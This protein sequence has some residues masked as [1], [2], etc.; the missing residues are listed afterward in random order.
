MMVTET[1][2]MVVMNQGPHKGPS[3]GEKEVDVVLGKIAVPTVHV[4]VI[5]GTVLKTLLSLLPSHSVF[6]E[7]FRESTNM[8]IYSIYLFKS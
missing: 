7:A 3:R 8:N 6:C 2:R 4:P 5:A 1:L